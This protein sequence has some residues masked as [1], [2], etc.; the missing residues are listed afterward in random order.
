MKNNF[1]ASLYTA[2][3]KVEEGHQ[4][5]PIDW[6]TLGAVDPEVHL[7][8]ECGT[9]WTYSA[10]GA[11]E[12]AHFVKSGQFVKF[13]EQQ[14]VDCQTTCNGCNYCNTIDAFNYY[15]DNYAVAASLYPNKGVKQECMYA[16][17]TST[18]IKAASVKMVPPKSATQ[19]KLALEKGPISIAIQIN[20]ESNFRHY[21]SGI[22]NGDCGE[23]EDGS[24]MLN[25]D[26]LL[27]GWGTVFGIDYWIAKNSWGK[28]WGVK[29]YI[30]IRATADGTAGICGAQ[31]YALYPVLA[32][33]EPVP[34]PVVQ[35]QTT[36]PTEVKKDVT[37]DTK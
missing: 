35:P 32:D 20:D 33:P 1:D 36:E 18:L 23:Y 22:F 11:L 29:G 3:L 4:S 9:G 30:N 21:E 26:L 25:H 8:S 13:S 15:V 10:T 5:Y 27:V 2:T 34:L 6:R 31:L 12:G 28:L 24:I 14:L 19:M 17:D 16:A 37:Q 7:E